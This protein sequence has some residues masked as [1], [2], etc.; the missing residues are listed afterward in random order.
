MT[1]RAKEL[2]IKKLDKYRAKGHDLDEV[3]E[4]SIENSYQG[5]FEPKQD[6]K[7]PETLNEA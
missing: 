5:L 4:Y 7:K 1:E 3:L 2:A 6:Q